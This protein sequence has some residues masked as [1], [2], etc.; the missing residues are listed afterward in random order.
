[1]YKSVL[2]CPNIKKRKNLWLV[3]YLPFSAQIMKTPYLD[4]VIAFNIF[5]LPTFNYFIFNFIQIGQQTKTKVANV[6]AL[7]T[8]ATRSNGE[9]ACAACR[10]LWENH[11]LELLWVLGTC[12]TVL[13]SLSSGLNCYSCSWLYKNVK[14]RT[15]V[16]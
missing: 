8:L 13:L 5:Y 16:L 2:L 1:M 3:K 9:C 6:R 4:M 14:K 11:C 12:G 10:P 15:N 7:T